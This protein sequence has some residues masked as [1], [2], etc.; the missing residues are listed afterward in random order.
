MDSCVDS[1]PKSVGYMEQLDYKDSGATSVRHMG[2][3]GMIVRV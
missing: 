1:G 3:T 2:G